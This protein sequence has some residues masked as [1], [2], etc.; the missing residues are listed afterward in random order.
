VWIISILT[1]VS[2]FAYNITRSFLAFVAYDSVT[3]INIDRLPSIEFPTVTF[4]N[5]SPFKT[6]ANGFIFKNAFNFIESTFATN[7]YFSMYHVSSI[8]LILQYLSKALLIN[9]S[10]TDSQRAMLGFTIDDMLISCR[11]NNKV[12]NKSD[13]EY[14]YTYQYGNCYKFNSGLNS[15]NQAVDKKTATNPGLKD[16]LRLELFVGYPQPSLDFVNTNGIVL[17]VHNSTIAPLPEIEGF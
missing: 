3:Q 7:T 2:Y 13:F 14:F 8:L 10:V 1:S 5:K 9:W 4:C 16:A 17:L 11:Y 15:V 12:C 6:Y